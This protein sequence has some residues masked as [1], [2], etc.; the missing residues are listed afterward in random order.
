M[1]RR[2][3]NEQRSTFLTRQSAAV[4]NDDIR[5]DPAKIIYSVTIGS[6]GNEA[7]YMPLSSVSNL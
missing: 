2:S 5:A 6:F 3:W 1:G 4:R 7:A